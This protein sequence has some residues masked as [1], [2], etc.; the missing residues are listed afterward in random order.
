MKRA[1]GEGTIKK[2][3]NGTWEGQ[4]VAGRDEKG[5]L[6]RRSVYGK[7]QA[8]VRKKLS[9]VTN[10]LD[11]GVYIAPAALTVAEWFDIWLNEYNG[12]VKVSTKS[13]YDYQGRIHIKPVIGSIKLQKITAPILQKFINDRFENGL[14]PNH[15]GIYMECCISCSI[16]LFFVDI[17][18][19]IRSQPFSSPV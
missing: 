6:I 19:A 7:T 14:S 4:Y 2:R 11:T 12:S 10:V 5:K 13:Q 15:A 3:K 1:N 16:R 8:E 18:R 17:S 9:A